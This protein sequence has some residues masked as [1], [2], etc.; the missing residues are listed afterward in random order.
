MTTEQQMTQKVPH[1]LRGIKWH[2]CS[3]RELELLSE[4]GYTPAIRERAGYEIK[5]RDE[6]RESISDRM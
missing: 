2:E 3:D 6:S 5:R 4:H 1:G